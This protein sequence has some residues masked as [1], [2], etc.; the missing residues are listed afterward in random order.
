M[1]YIDRYFERF[2]GTLPQKA[3]VG[4]LLFVLL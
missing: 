2:P 4:A 1:S 3:F